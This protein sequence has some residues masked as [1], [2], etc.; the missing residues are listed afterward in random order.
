MESIKVK[1]LCDEC[2]NSM[3]ADVYLEAVASYG[4]EMGYE[5]QYQG[6]TII[7]CPNCNNEITIKAE[8]WEYPEG[9]INN[10]QNK[11][12]GGKEIPL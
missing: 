4:R 1:V 2:N 8:V 7:D 6:E 9:V 10:S 12:F 5:T 3:S 11:V